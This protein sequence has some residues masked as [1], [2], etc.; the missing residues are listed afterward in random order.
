M[1]QFL[2]E[3]GEAQEQSVEVAAPVQSVETNIKTE[4]QA[5]INT[6][7]AKTSAVDEAGWEDEVAPS[8]RL[9]LS[10]SYIGE[11]AREKHL[12]N[13]IRTPNKTDGGLSKAA[14]TALEVIMANQQCTNKFEVFSTLTLR[15]KDWWK[16]SKAVAVLRK[17]YDNN[18]TD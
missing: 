16:K 14:E 17:R 2:E 1:T 12:I 4:V 18:N 13:L 3:F 11:N 10:E 6:L 8:K 7:I 15:K 5:F 9:K